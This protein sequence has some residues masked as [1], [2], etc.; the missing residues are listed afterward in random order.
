[1]WRSV[2]AVIAACG[3]SPPD[4]THAGDGTRAF[5]KQH[6][7]DAKSELE[8]TFATKMI[9]VAPERIVRH[10][11]ADQWSVEAI[12]CGAIDAERC[13]AL[14]TPAQQQA[15]RDDAPELTKQ[16]TLDLP[17]KPPPPMVSV[18]RQGI[19]FAGK[20]LASPDELAQVL[21]QHPADPTVLLHADASTSMP[22]IHEVILACKRAGYDNVLFDVKQ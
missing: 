5:W 9:E 3:N 11:K 20:Q 10:C 17:V 14:L 8:R 18:S 19:E 22:L 12:A 4:C 1:M 16:Q 6:L 7:A 13:L 21:P 15:L 2:L